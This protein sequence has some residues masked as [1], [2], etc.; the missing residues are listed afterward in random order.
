[1]RGDGEWCSEAKTRTCERFYSVPHG[2][3]LIFTIKDFK[4][5]KDMCTFTM[6]R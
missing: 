2:L 6:G 3:A 4:L 5:K 1:M